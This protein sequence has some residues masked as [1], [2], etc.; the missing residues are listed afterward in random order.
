MKQE[1]EKLISGE[2]TKTPGGN[3]RAI[4]TPPYMDLFA[5][6]ENIPYKDIVK[7]GA[8]A[9]D[10]FGANS[11]LDV[12]LYGCRLFLHQHLFTAEGN[13]MPASFALSYNPKYGDT[14][15]VHNQTVIFKRW[16][17][18]YQQ[19][20]HFKEGNFIYVDGS[21]KEHVFEKS[22]FNNDIY[23]D[24]STQ[25]GTLLRPATG[26]ETSLYD[27]VIFDD[28]GT[29]MF[30][31]NNRLVKVTQT[32]GSTPIS[33]LITYDS[34]G[35]VHKVTDGLG[36]D[37]F[38]NYLGSIVTITKAD[39]SILV[40][41]TA[42]TDN[43][44]QK[45]TY[46]DGKECLFEKDIFNR[47]SMIE[48][49][50]AHEKLY[51]AY[52]GD[53]IR[54]A[55]KYSCNENDETPL[56][57][58]FFYFNSDSHYTIVS[59]N[60][61]LHGELSADLGQIRNKYKF[62]DKGILVDSHEIDQ[63]DQP[64]GL[65]SCKPLVDGAD[66]TNIYD[67]K[68]KKDLLYGMDDMYHNANSM[69]GSPM[70][71][72]NETLPVPAYKTGANLFISW[73]LYINTID[74]TLPTGT[75]FCDCIVDGVTVC[76]YA[77]DCSK[78][79]PH[80]SI[81]MVKDLIAGETT[82]VK[83]QMRHEN[84]AF[85]VRFFDVRAWFAPV[86]K[87][88]VRLNVTPSYNTDDYKT[89][90]TE[91]LG[92]VKR[93]W[94]PTEYIKFHTNFGLVEPESFTVA[95]Y[96]KTMLSYFKNPSCFNFFYN[97]CKNVVY[98][99]T[100]LMIDE[101]GEYMSFD[102]SIFAIME[103]SLTGITSFTHF[104][105]E[106]SKLNIHKREKND[107]FDFAYTKLDTYLRKSSEWSA[108]SAITTYDYDTFG[109]VKDSH[110]GGS[111][112]ERTTSIYSANGQQ[113]VESPD[114]M[115]TDTHTTT[116]A[117]NTNG[118]LSGVTT[119][120]N[121]TTSFEY[122]D[123]N[124]LKKVS[125]SVDDATNTIDSNGAFISSLA[126]NGTTFQF[127]YDERNNIS[128]VKVADATLMS[129][130]AAYDT[131]GSFCTRSVYSNQEVVKKYYDKYGRIIRVSDC[132]ND[133]DVIAKFIYSDEEVADVVTEPTDGRLTIS[134][135]SQ[136]RVVIDVVA[137]TRTV[138]TYDG[139]GQVS[140]VD[141]EETSTVQTQDDYN[142]VTQI[143]QSLKS[144]DD[145]QMSYQY[146]STKDSNL[147]TELTQLD[148][149]AFATTY[150][151]DNLSRPTSV[152]VMQ[153]TIG[154]KYTYDYIPR[155]TRTWV[156]IGGG[157]IIHPGS[158]D[159]GVVSPYALNGHWQIDDVGTTPYISQFKEYSMSG[160]TETFVRADEVQ[161]DA[162]GNITKYG[163]VTYAY[164]GLNRLVRENNPSIDKTFTWCYD[165]GGNIVNRTEYAYTTGTLGSPTATMAYAYGS[166]WKDQLTSFN[167]SSIV[168][169]NAGNPTTYRGKSLGWTRGRLLASYGATGSNYITTMQYDASGI[170]REKLVPSAYGSTTTT[171]FYNGNNLVQEKVVNKVSVQSHTH[172]KTYLYNSQGVIGFVQGSNTY[173]YRKNLFGDIV[174]LYK[175][176]TKVAEYAYDA[177][178]NCTV[179][180][181][182]TGNVST[183][184][185][186]IGNQNPF[187]YR[188]YYWD[189]DLQLYYL[190]S[191]YYDPA[192]GRFIN[193]DMLDY[194][195]P[196]SINGLNLYAYCGNDPVNRFDP[197]GHFWDYI[198]DGIFICIGT[199]ELIKDPSWDKAGW[200]ALDVILAVLPI[201]P[202]LSS[203]RHLNKVD[204]LFDLA[205][206]YGHIDNFADSGGIIR[207][208]ID[209]DFIDNGWDL[210][211]GLNK[212]EDGFTI[213]HRLTGTKIHSKFIVGE[214]ADI[215]NSLN[216]VDGIDRSLKI[217][218]ELKPYNKISIRRGIKQLYR[219]QKAVFESTGE[220]YRL[221]LVLY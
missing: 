87:N 218:Y 147:Q 204:D 200:L 213:S 83:L 123:R 141:N 70:E 174:A 79:I 43:V 33:T 20:L 89:R 67:V 112:G 125:N 109:N 217:I 68:N 148:S 57:N 130:F 170:R 12:N 142:R 159:E 140:R 162:N 160:T 28:A 205:K 39:G 120:L 59:K 106:G 168:Y 10:S 171:F 101:L 49:A 11:A 97:D 38:V 14:N 104:T 76:T 37:Y 77:Y 181:P 136:L 110:F 126:H 220:L 86:T 113:I 73:N 209:E 64:I 30:F 119:P 188:G 186:F 146:V 102:D 114:Y 202:A 23:L 121:A 60:V 180:D 25:S 127:L 122:K 99:V 47:I 24:T 100:S 54:Y 169:D 9:Q 131:D 176:A 118:M 32:K 166:A 221:V 96:Q 164:D 35:R 15:A 177:W 158:I 116:F 185:V 172:Y 151:R 58:V 91:T 183:S 18:N 155:Q 65:Q 154:H 216:K 74:A 139:F 94:F 129:K 173:T 36:N 165:I 80:E 4:N 178:G 19:F 1:N 175:G 182:A 56:S 108:S 42:T 194:L 21:F 167:G 44:L 128:E 103:V 7:N 203:A 192:T 82:T 179:I 40:T 153:G 13:L 5:P 132:T 107:P 156:P 53:Q 52:N 46:L 199:Y 81:W 92:S 219:Y 206:A 29:Q 189:N 45:I 16:K 196:D 133:E 161:Y 207:R 193:A 2:E 149:T 8:C 48:D 184:D 31:K 143:T 98:G 208:A 138:F 117:Y 190:M 93:Y 51:L 124:V 144:G 134:S 66:A 61:I 157:Q 135:S 69:S 212:T 201:I 137:G 210:V 95:D 111:T 72:C 62:N 90:V 63:D 195:E 211:K 85:P 187:R 6:D 88:E 34:N 26:D 55:S 163:N 214:G 197:S 17:L 152:K 150:T 27:H 191:R 78:D 115:Y 50:S 71:I 41:L 84:N 145:V 215:I 75:V 105:I 3:S 22:T 198:L